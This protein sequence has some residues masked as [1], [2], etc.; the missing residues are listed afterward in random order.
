MST[1]AANQAIYDRLHGMQQ[2]HPGTAT[3][4]SDWTVEPGDVIEIQNGTDE[5]GDPTYQIL[6]V[7]QL[8][9]TWNGA[10]MT[11]IQATGNEK[12]PP[13]SALRRSTF[14]A[15]R[16]GAAAERKADEA[17]EEVIY[18]T[19]I[20][21]DDTA[22][23]LLAAAIGV[24]IDSETGLPARDDQ[25]NY[26]W[27]GDDGA[28]LTGRLSVRADQIISEVVQARGNQ[29][30]LGS[31][32]SQTESNISLV[33]TNG[34]LDAAKI[35]L[36]VNGGSGSNAII[37]ADKVDLQGYVTAT[38]LAAG[39]ISAI[40]VG[41]GSLTAGSITVTDATLT[42]ITSAGDTT[43][44]A[45]Y[46]GD[47]T[48]GS[49]TWLVTP[50][51]LVK[52]L[53]ITPPA[54]GSNDYTLT[55]TTADGQPHIL[56][57]S[58][59]AQVTNVSGTWNGSTYTVAADATASGAPLPKSVTLDAILAGG[60]TSDFSAQIRDTSSG[61]SP[62]IIDSDAAHG[63][64]A[65]SGNSV[66]VYT[67]RSGSTYSGPVASLS[68]QSEINTAATNAKNT[69]LAG[70][71]L[72]GWQCNSSSHNAENI[73][74]DVDNNDLNVVA[75][76]PPS[77]DWRVDVGAF[78]SSGSAIIT[79]TP[80]LGGVSCNPVTTSTISDSN[81]LPE[82]IKSGVTIF[83]KTGTYTGSGGP[84][85]SSVGLYFDNE[86]LEDVTTPFSVD[87]DYT[88]YP[89]AKMSDG[90]RRVGSAVRLTTT[91]SLYDV[92]TITPTSSAQTIAVPTGYA[93]F[94][95]PLRI[96]AASGGSSYSYSAKLNRNSELYIKDGSSYY[97]LSALNLY[98][99]TSANTY[100]QI[101]SGTTVHW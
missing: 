26:L 25:G 21:Q 28:T 88:V 55:W 1:T 81:L 27:D 87:N 22:I 40:S 70:V 23:G 18:R 98:G 76:L 56:T 64:L 65:K 97:P 75:S 67:S 96:A 72:S 66:V 2:F 7:Y 17:L 79:V 50:Q 95:G 69:A 19:D 52:S 29:T 30:D 46:L 68:F 32:I 51:N 78:N 13:L 85:V 100:T 6:P 77:S 14:S 93:G 99:Y 9:M 101:P 4:L 15:G 49:A 37:S 91:I 41:S 63:Y 31:R 86:G 89:I 90:T 74:R 11:D 44:D 57:F 38:E 24:K 71:K 54:S 12:R 60:G 36:A 35:I 83:G 20:T 43:I 42:N 16:G 45:L 53:E 34:A 10:C 82:N 59:A 94:A 3:L 80:V 48:A 62:V 58:R 47:G 73:V 33:V 84:S 61:P 5:N 8:D 92:G 39:T